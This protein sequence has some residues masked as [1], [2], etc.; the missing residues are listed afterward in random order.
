MSDAQFTQYSNVRLFAEK[1][2]KFH[3][4]DSALT[5]D[6][7]RK[8]MQPNKYIKIDY[9]NNTSGKQV[10]IYLFAHDSKHALASQ[11]LRKLIAKNKDESCEIILITAQPLKVYANKVVKSF[12]NLEINCYLHKNFESEIP[13]GPLCYPHRIMSREEVNILLNNQ[14]CC[15]L[16]NLPKILEEDPQC[17]WIG[18]KVCDVVEIIMVSD[19][20]GETIQHRVV[21]TKSGKAISF[22]KEIISQVTDVNVEDEDEDAE[23]KEFREDAKNETSDYEDAEDVDTNEDA[24]DAEE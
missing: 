18:A 3:P 2:R 1:W 14:L 20:S 21:V 5:H 17:I 22:K 24:E 6:A 13:N 4:V 23:I 15:N 7:F 16:P 11:D 10:Y 9:V 12:K 8:I 19:I